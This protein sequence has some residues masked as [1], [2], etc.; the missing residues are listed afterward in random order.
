MNNKTLLTLL[1]ILTCHFVSFAQITIRGKVTDAQN[2]GIPGVSIMVKGST[3]GAST[4]A[5]GSYSIAAPSSANTLVFTSL[6]FATREIT[7]A[8]RTQINV[9]LSSQE[10]NLDDVV[11]TALGI[12]RSEKSIGYATQ[13]VK[14]DNLTL[15]KEQNVI[16]SLAGKIAGVQVT[17]SSGA[18][19]G[20]TQK[21]KIRSVNSLTGGGSPL[22]VVDGTPI[23]Q[24]NFSG[25]ENGV[26]YGNTSQD[27]NPDDIES[28]NVLKG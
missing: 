2:V 12:K 3:T 7:I 1:G 25:G 20:G 24:S 14:G 15:T 5:D 19:L 11:V 6:G 22:M 26:D 16:G 17:G 13:S 27:I 18:S 10:N 8:G 4:I 9:Q 21:I 23:A 28:V